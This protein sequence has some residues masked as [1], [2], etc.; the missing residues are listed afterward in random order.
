[1]SSK[2][3]LTCSAAQGRGLQG[4]GKMRLQAAQELCQFPSSFAF[5]CF[6]CRVCACARVTLLITG[7]LPLLGWGG[8]G[9]RH[10]C[11]RF[12]TTVLIASG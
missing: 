10:E 7:C 5:I 4:G 12:T 11:Q 6:S 8:N 2:R 9:G 1:M 3:E